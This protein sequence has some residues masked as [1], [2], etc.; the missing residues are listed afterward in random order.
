MF[1]KPFQVETLW[2]SEMQKAGHIPLLLKNP[3]INTL[4]VKK[5]CEK[6]HI[7]PTD[8]YECHRINRLAMS[9]NEYSK[10]YWEDVK[11]R[12]AIYRLR[13]TIKLST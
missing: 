9:Y 11:S 8:P 12:Q 6:R 1:T 10:K 13:R 7:D 2:R 3:I 5:H 4:K